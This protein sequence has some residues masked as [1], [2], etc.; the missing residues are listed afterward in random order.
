MDALGFL[1]HG[2]DAQ[3]FL[4]QEHHRSKDIK[5]MGM[6]AARVRRHSWILDTY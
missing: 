3:C 4:G 5:G 2:M 1:G 6:N